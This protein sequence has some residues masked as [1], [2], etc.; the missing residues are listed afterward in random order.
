[1]TITRH[2]GLFRR[3][4]RAAMIA[5]VGAVGI[6]GTAYATGVPADDSA[7]STH[8]AVGEFC[9]WAERDYHGALHRFDLRTTNPMECVPLPEEFDALAFANRTDREV[10]VYQGR[11]CSTEGDFTTYPG[12]GTY[13]PEAPF[14]VR[15]IQIWE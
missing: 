9:A 3:A 1:M 12:R 15:A 6:T 7:R 4:L 11:D 13:V 5:T 10:T 14:V 8:C 2:R